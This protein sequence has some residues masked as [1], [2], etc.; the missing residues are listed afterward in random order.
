MNRQGGSFNL[1]K[2]S[3]V[4]N[5]RK[6]T[7]LLAL[8]AM[9][10]CSRV[11][12]GQGSIFI[13]PP[14][15]GPATNTTTILPVY[16]WNTNMQS[17]TNF[18]LAGPP[19]LFTNFTMLSNLISGTILSN[20]GGIDPGSVTIQIISWN[21]D[22]AIFFGPLLPADPVHLPPFLSPSPTNDNFDDAIEL[23]GTVF[24]FT[25]NNSMATVEPGEPVH[26][27][28]VTPG[29]STW[30]RWTPVWNGQTAIRHSPFGMVAVYTG[31][32]S[33]DALQRVELATTSW[34]YGFMVGDAEVT[35]LFQAQAGTTYYI[36][37]DTPFSSFTLALDELLLVLDPVPSRAAVGQTILR[38]DS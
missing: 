27:T 8:V 12:V 22:P 32:V 35:S 14:Y 31:G 19:D 36:A 4:F 3:S 34:Q 1:P 10:G 28:D 37:M 15:F 17:A 38:Q 20:W 16:I 7:G 9:L 29:H 11:A 18:V 23:S 13:N 33:V 24:G 25:V 21:G 30:W 6:V 26:G 2:G 5:L